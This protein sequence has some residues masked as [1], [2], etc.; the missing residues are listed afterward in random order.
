M[1]SVNRLP[2]AS[3]LD[4]VMQGVGQME[5]QV[6]DLDVS[7]THRLLECGRGGVD[8]AAGVGRHTLFMLLGIIRHLST[9]QPK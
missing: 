8:P 7:G 9:F 3:P 6:K 4:P 1:S 5:Y 2:V